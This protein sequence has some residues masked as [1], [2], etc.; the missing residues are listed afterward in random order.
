M[1]EEWATFGLLVGG[2][3]AALAGLLFVAVS[4]NL[5]RITPHRSLRSRA[6]ET[7]LLLTPLFISILI[8]IPAQ[9]TWQLGLELLARAGITGGILFVLGRRVDRS[10]TSQAEM[11]SRHIRK[12]S[13]TLTTML[14]LG[15]SGGS[16]I[17]GRG[18]GCYWLVPAVVASFVSGVL[19]AWLLMISIG[20][21]GE[22]R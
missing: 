19:N 4:V 17:A 5:A 13:L 10:G 16:L 22:G 11:L 21:Q 15:L 8:T 14:L 6:A 20:D 7:L 18:G 9:R 1:L 12:L 2:A 3:S